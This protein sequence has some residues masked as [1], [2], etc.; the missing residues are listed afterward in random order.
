[1]Y[2]ADW[3][4]L[5]DKAG[6]THLWAGSNPVSF[7]KKRK[8]ILSTCSIRN[9]LS[10]AART[11]LSLSTSKG[12]QVQILPIAA[13][14]IVAEWSKAIEAQAYQC[15]FAQETVLSMSWADVMGYRCSVYPITQTCSG[16]AIIWH[17]PLD[18]GYQS[19]P[20]SYSLTAA[21]SIS[22]HLLVS[23]HLL[24]VVSAVS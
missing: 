5:P 18:V 16:H 20:L 8:S 2:R 11:G 14:S 23:L 9:Y 17:E 6:V 19:H 3:H 15:S 1:M 12:S 21:L 13:M 4:R 22:I 24:E 10:W 7:R